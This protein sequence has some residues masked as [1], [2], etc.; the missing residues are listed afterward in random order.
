MYHNDSHICLILINM[1]RGGY[2]FGRML[3]IKCPVPVK[4]A[5]LIGCQ[6]GNCSKAELW[7]GCHLSGRAFDGF[8]RL[9]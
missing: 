1:V 4:S 5:V 3:E 6:V 9:L 8:F 7:S 2:Y